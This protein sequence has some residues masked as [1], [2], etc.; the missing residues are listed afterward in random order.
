M[1]STSRA[2]VGAGRS[3][4]S[5]WR[6]PAGS[7]D[8]CQLNGLSRTWERSSLLQ[9]YRASTWGRSSPLSV[10]RVVIG[11]LGPRRESHFFATL[12]HTRL[13]NDDTLASHHES[14]VDVTPANGVVRLTLGVSRSAQRGTLLLEH[15]IERTHSF[16]DH[17]REQRPA[18]RRGEMQRSLRLARGGFRSGLGSLPQ[19]E[20]RRVSP[21][22]DANAKRS[23]SVGDRLGLG[24]G[25][26]RFWTKPPGEKSSSWRFL[27]GW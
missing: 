8:T 19:E 20:F 1:K 7:G 14:P 16:L 18:H 22:L 27:F 10:E 4:K 9:R 13:A 12:P 6:P 26:G 3:T 25:G 15:L 11:E 21:T 2:E 17:E 5:P 24:P 23:D